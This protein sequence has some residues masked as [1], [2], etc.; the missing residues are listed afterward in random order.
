MRVSQFVQCD[1]DKQVKLLNKSD[2]HKQPKL[3]VRFWDI[4]TDMCTFTGGEVLMFDI[5]AACICPKSHL[6]ATYFGRET[7]FRTTRLG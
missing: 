7:E 5:V 2:S 6:P 3:R 1:L 4:Y